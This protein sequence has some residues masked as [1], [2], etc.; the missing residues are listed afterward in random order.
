MKLTQD[1]LSFWRLFKFTLSTGFCCAKLLAFYTSCVHCL[2]P[3]FPLFL[4][5]S[6]SPIYSHS[7]NTSNTQTPQTPRTPR[8]PRTSTLSPRYPA[9]SICISISTPIYPTQHTSS[10]HP[11]SHIKSHQTPSNP[12][13][14]HPIPSPITPY[15]T[16]PTQ[17]QHTILTL[18]Q[19]PPV[20]YSSTPPA[21]LNPIHQLPTPPITTALANTFPST[22]TN[23]ARVYRYQHQRDYGVKQLL[24]PWRNQ[25]QRREG[26]WTAWRCREASEES[27]EERRLYV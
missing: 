7:L 15:P 23:T 12:I 22:V 17:P 1:I 27:R 10:T 14:S 13:P 18:P 16:P 5:S 11:A 24:R 2:I 6:L 19:N 4:L 20:I 26:G 25:Y 8:T 9:L 21:S 3:F